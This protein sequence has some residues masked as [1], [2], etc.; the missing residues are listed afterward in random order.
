MN[1]LGQ[2]FQRWERLEPTLPA[3]LAERRV[4]FR[5]LILK[6]HEAVGR[7]CSSSTLGQCL[8]RRCFQRAGAASVPA[9]YPFK[10]WRSHEGGYDC[11]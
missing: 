2:V 11:H 3:W 10:H 5:E 4:V 8:C 9:I 1:L 6:V 7:F